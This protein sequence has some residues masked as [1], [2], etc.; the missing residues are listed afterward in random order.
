VVG[1]SDTRSGNRGYPELAG[2]RGSRLPPGPSPA[3]H[4]GT[5]HML[6]CWGPAALVFHDVKLAENEAVSQPVPVQGQFARACWLQF[7]SCS[8]TKAALSHHI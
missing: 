1:N 3:H 7:D 5:S 2:F 4:L 6:C 8:S